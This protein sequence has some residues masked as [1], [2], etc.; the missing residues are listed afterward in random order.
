MS[1]DAFSEHF[2]HL[3]D[4]RQSAKISYP[5]FDV[6][7]LVVCAVI[8]GCE[9]WEDIEDFGEVHLDWL[10]EKGFFPD[11]LPTHDT[12]ARIVSRL[13]PTEFQTSFASWM[14]AISQRSKGE[15]IAIDG[16]VLRGSYD[17]ESRQS[18]IHMVS[19]FATANGVV[20]GQRKTDAKSNE[21]T[22]IPEL[23]QLL[24]IKG[25]LVSI[26]AI[27]CQTNIA[28]TIT[29]E[30]GDY[31]LAVKGNQESLFKAVQHALKEK[32]IAKSEPQNVTIEKGH[33]RVEAREYH[34]LP[35][36]ELAKQFPEW[37]GL[38]SIGFALSCRVDNKGKSSFEYRY[39]ISSAELTNTEFAAAVRGHWGIENS[40]HW[41]L[42]ATMNEDSCQ[43]YR[44]NAAEVMACI[45]HIALNMLRSEN[46]KK[47]SVRRKQKIAAMSNDY[48][49]KVLLAGLDASN[50]N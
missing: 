28:A 8:A 11:G 49:D 47:A 33:G 16:K 20:V 2:G 13:E 37:K 38:K 14:Q 4:P 15:L 45:R 36:G 3:T 24:D 7:F 22:A 32:R 50:N 29:D 41:V 26:D 21:I 40:L 42:D 43:I 35:A 1:I 34:V 23:L 30:G 25:C 46:T 44:N 5:L 18:T 19:A 10:Q 39:Y 17:R 6:L 31:L 48:L 27:G 9:G 12:I